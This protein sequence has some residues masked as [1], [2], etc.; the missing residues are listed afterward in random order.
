MGVELGIWTIGVMLL[1]GRP[2]RGWWRQVL[3]PPCLSI[4]FALAVNFVYSSLEGLAAPA[5]LAAAAQAIGQAIHWLGQSAIPMAMVLI[6]ATV[7][8]QLHPT[9]EKEPERAASASKV[10]FWA[11]LLR[12][13]LLPVVFLAIGLLVP[14]TVELKRV[15]AIEAAMPSAVF[16][17]VMTRHYGGNPATALRV[18]LGTSLVSLVTIPFWIH[19]GLK[20]FGLAGPG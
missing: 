18:V 7:A 17:I 4:L 9:E 2:G 15:L 13:G 14:G 5:I 3:N 1:S 20:L 16:P 11:C 12:L 8:D 19:A 10:V 6:G